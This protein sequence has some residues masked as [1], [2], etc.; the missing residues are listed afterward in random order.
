MLFNVR[1]VVLWV[2]AAALG[3]V[4]VLSLGGMINASPSGVLVVE[5]DSATVGQVL[6]TGIPKGDEC[7]MSSDAVRIVL[8]LSETK[9]TADLTI[10]IDENCV[11]S[12]ADK[13]QTVGP[14][15]SVFMSSTDRYRAMAKSE[16]S[17]FAG[18]DLA[19]V[20]VRYTYDES[21]SGFSFVGSPSEQCVKAAWWRTKACRM[22]RKSATSS[23]IKATAYGKFS[24]VGGAYLHSQKPT[25]TSRPGGKGKATCWSSTHLRSLT[26]NCDG[27]LTRN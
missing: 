23:Q 9:P 3:L 7:V 14:V 18:I 17:D 1:N 21:S 11:M 2:V 4:A 22:D 5:H 27:S 25:F 13:N 12:I 26:S 8:D 19:V 6:Q 16:W 24:L 10:R 20:Y 15:G